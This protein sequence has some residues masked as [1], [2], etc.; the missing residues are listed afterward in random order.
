VAYV[1][2]EAV[3]ATFLRRLLM[4]RPSSSSDDVK[5][6]PES[7][8]GGGVAGF[9][10]KLALPLARFLKPNWGTASATSVSSGMLDDL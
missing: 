3:T 4:R 10:R 2:D 5:S 6:D 7:E 9:L 1:A 8:A